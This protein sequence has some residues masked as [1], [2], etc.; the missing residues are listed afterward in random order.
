MPSAACPVKYEA[1]LTR[2]RGEHHN[3]L[4]VSYQNRKGGS[5]LRLTLARRQEEE[6][7]SQD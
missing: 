4:S 3:R 5:S 7:G 1:Y 6:D 2:V